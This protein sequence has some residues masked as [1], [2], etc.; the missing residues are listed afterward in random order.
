MKCT[1]EQQNYDNRKHVE[2]KPNKTEKEGKKTQNSDFNENDQFIAAI[3]D[4]QL[5]WPFAIKIS[6]INGANDAESVRAIGSVFILFWL[7]FEADKMRIAL[8]FNND[9]Q[10]YR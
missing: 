1:E 7:F 6:C 4:N 8:P 3:W 9:V 10:R 2:N 5:R